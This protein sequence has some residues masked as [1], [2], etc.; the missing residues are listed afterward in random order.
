MNNDLYIC[1]N[2][3]FVQEQ[4]VL[5]PDN[6]AFRYGDGLFETMRLRQG[7]LLWVHS[8]FERLLAGMFTL[9]IDSSLF[10]PVEISRQILELASLNQ[11]SNGRVRVAVFREEGGNYKPESD[12]FEYII[13]ISPLPD[14]N[15]R[16]NT[17]GLRLG[18]Y[19]EIRKP[20]NMLSTLKSSNA[21]LYVMAS[22][23]AR[24]HSFDEVL[25]LNE[26]G[27]ICE[28]SSSNVFL[29]FPGG[30]IISP[31][32]SEGI[33]PGV[34]RKNIIVRMK[35]AGFQVEETQVLPEDLYRAEE[36]FLTNA[37]QG[38]RWVLSYRERRYYKNQVQEI[39]NLLLPLQVGS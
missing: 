34:M 6:R 35:E 19:T 23:Y 30:R 4:Q 12:R 20:A 13:T 18:L 14:E 8:H 7:N 33:L 29:I 39:N 22:R 28:A 32:S 36:I 31:A 1:L 21:L 3:R 38:F 27:R 5:S 24:D 26:Q 2:G 15:Y 37:I 11:I 25:I 16:L 10:N 17:K 9:G